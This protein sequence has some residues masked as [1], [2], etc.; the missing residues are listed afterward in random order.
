[1]EPREVG[2]YLVIDPRL[3]FGKLTFKGTRI[4]VATVLAYLARG[5][6]VERVL[7]GWPELKREAVAE[8]VQ[9]AAAALLEKYPQVRPE[10]CHEPVHPG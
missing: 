1:M 6:T 4:P 5:E 8:A 2:K 3:C 9:L 10:T 7:E